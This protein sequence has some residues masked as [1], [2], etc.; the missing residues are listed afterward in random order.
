MGKYSDIFD[1]AQ[2]ARAADQ[3]KAQSIKEARLTK[4]EENLALG[5]KWLEENVIK[6]LSSAKDELHGKALIEYSD[7]VRSEQ[8]PD[9]IRHFVSFSVSPWKSSS[10]IPRTIEIIATENGMIKS[11]I[12]K[13]EQAFGGGLSQIKFEEFQ[14]FLASLVRTVARL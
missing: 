9:G 14:S 11:Y 5:K 1:N 10:F 6:E 7:H 2:A 12:G 13:M 4:A 8:T 3:A